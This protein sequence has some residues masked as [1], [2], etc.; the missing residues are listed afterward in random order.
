MTAP[1]TAWTSL[2]PLFVSAGGDEYLR[3]HAIKVYQLATAHGVQCELDIM[4]H[5]GH[6]V[7]SF[8][9]YLG[10]PEGHEALGAMAFWTR[11]QVFGRAH[12]HLFRPA[13]D[14]QENRG[15]GGGDGDGRKKPVMFPKHGKHGVPIVP[16][17]S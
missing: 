15:G 5:V 9:G 2:P 1:P 17:N 14:T 6:A 11:K 7:V 8:V 13:A 4:P 10:V 3:D 16:Q 12:D